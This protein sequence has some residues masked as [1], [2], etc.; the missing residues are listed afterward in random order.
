MLSS[1]NARPNG[2]TH[3]LIAAPPYNTVP[4]ERKITHHPFDEANEIRGRDLDDRDRAPVLQPA[5]HAADAGDCTRHITPD[6]GVFREFAS[7]GAGERR[8]GVFRRAN[9]ALTHFR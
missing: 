5:D 3:N 7:Q 4:V 2:R 1:K 6:D 9:L 8:L